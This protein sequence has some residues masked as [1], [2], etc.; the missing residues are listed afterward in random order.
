MALFKSFLININKIVERIY[1]TGYLPMPREIKQRVNAV[2]GQEGY[3]KFLENMNNLP[4]IFDPLQGFQPVYLIYDAL[5]IT[6]NSPFECAVYVHGG[7][8][9]PI[10]EPINTSIVYLD[11]VTTYPLIVFSLLIF[12]GLMTLKRQKENN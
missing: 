3:N 2:C 11:P 9:P 12:S 5:S 1:A 6:V 7:W 8:S 10:Y 4:E